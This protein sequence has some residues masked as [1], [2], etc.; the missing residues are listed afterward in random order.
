LVWFAWLA[1]PGFSQ[2]QPGRLPNRGRITRDAGVSFLAVVA[3]TFLID[4]PL[5]QPWHGFT[6]RLSVTYLALAGVTMLIGV[7]A[8]AIDRHR[9]SPTQRG[10]TAV[11][12]ATALL[13]LWIACFPDL[14]RG[15][16]SVLD[17]AQARAM[18]DLIAEMKPVRNTADLISLLLNGAL[19]AVFVVCY[20]VKRRSML[21]GYAALSGVVLVGLGQS[22]F[23]F[24]TYPAIF[25]AAVLPIC[26][27]CLQARVAQ[28]RDGWQAAARLTL[29][30]VVFVSGDATMLGTLLM[31]GAGAAEAA[32]EPDCSVRTV[33]PRL[34]PYAGQVVL[35][36]VNDVP[37]LLYRT[38][39]RTVG[40]LYHRNAAGF[41]RLRDAWISTP[42]DTTPPAVRATE[43]NYVLVCRHDTRPQAGMAEATLETTLARGAV[44]AW[45]DPVFDD[46]P[47]G[48]VLY[49]VRP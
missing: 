36:D 42:S 7:I 8:M 41:M 25:A 45:L 4:A 9:L 13:G 44:P 26:F 14:L 35:S 10:T 39:V 47:S 28:W 34:A 19:A 40:S 2:Y 20:A 23:R 12:A 21:L 49:R 15:A 24:T 16:E 29:F 46:R 22:H 11:L 27:G 38:G 37:E 18:L 17:P 32:T 48:F 5:E 6:D 30:C 43:A 33:A 3:A 1:Q 31:P